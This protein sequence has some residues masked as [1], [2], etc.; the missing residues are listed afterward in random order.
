MALR[1][2][3]R[4]FRLAFL[5]RRDQT[6]TIQSVSGSTMWQGRKSVAAL[7]GLAAFTVMGVNLLT[8]ISADPASLPGLL[9]PYVTRGDISY[10][11]DDDD[12]FEEY[13][14]TDRSKVLVNYTFHNLMWGAYY[15]I[16]SERYNALALNEQYVP[17]QVSVYF[18]D[19]DRDP[20]S[21]L[22][23]YKVHSARS[24]PS[25]GIVLVNLGFVTKLLQL[26]PYI[27]DATGLNILTS[28]DSHLGDELLVKIDKPLPNVVPWSLDELYANKALFICMYVVI[29][30]IGHIHDYD[31]L[32]E[33]GYRQ[34]PL[35]LREEYADQFFA[36]I[37][38]DLSK[39]KAMEPIYDVSFSLM[40]SGMLSYLSHHF[41]QSLGKTEFEV[42]T[43]GDQTFE[44]HDSI[45]ATHPPMA[46]RLLQVLYL[47]FHHRNTSLSE[48]QF[49]D[50]A[51]YKRLL[52]KVQLREGIMPW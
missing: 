43:S 50:E 37:F 45:L 34:K 32:G 25:V 5:N 15:A 19:P 39:S 46:H 7:I 31:V 40:T 13:A 26:K 49:G 35:K 29:H 16:Q 9:N 8:N 12:V 17:R 3:Q 36:S 23:R 4:K 2:L 51:V 24:F 20:S 42:W 14:T 28:N 18:I 30:E 33:E 10:V 52:E 1:A 6:L 21:I 47:I 38:A 11:A 22:Q 48:G 44:L 41:V 27:E